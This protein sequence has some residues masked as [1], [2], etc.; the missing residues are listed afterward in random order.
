M[1]SQLH[2]AKGK[3]FLKHSASSVNW[4]PKIS[5]HW[6]FMHSS[7]ISKKSSHLIFICDICLF[8][9]SWPPV[10]ST[11]RWKNRVSC[12]LL[13][14][15]IS[16]NRW[17]RTELIFLATSRDDYDPP[18]FRPFDLVCWS[19]H[20]LSKLKIN[21]NTLHITVFFFFIFPIKR[22]KEEDSTFLTLNW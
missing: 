7:N 1:I 6:N 5:E 18:D 2:L 20:L 16:M 14:Q 15:R 3:K 21:D 10:L 19:L 4:R 13:L 11:S 8:L 12:V 17:V 22:R 9:R